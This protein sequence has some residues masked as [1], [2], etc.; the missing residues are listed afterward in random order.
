M[1]TPGTR[2]R[3][4]IVPIMALCVT[5][6]FGFVALAVDLG[7]LAINRTECQNAADAAAL[8]GARQLNN[9][10]TSTNNNWTAADTEARR[11]GDH[12]N[13]FA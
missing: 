5:G 11:N 1:R 7:M 3:G 8:A 13:H 6:L 12:L 4:T 10:T 2:R 9:A